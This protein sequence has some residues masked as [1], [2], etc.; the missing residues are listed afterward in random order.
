MDTGDSLLAECNDNSTD[1][2]SD[3]EDGLSCASSDV[4]SEWTVPE[5][6]LPTEGFSYKYRSDIDTEKILEQ[7]TNGKDDTVDVLIEHDFAVNGADKLSPD[8][9]SAVASLSTK[10]SSR[11][12]PLPS[13]TKDHTNN[14]EQ[15]DSD[16]DSLESLSSSGSMMDESEDDNDE[17]PETSLPDLRSF[18]NHALLQYHLKNAQLSNTRDSSSRKSAIHNRSDPTPSGQKQKRQR[19]ASTA[20]SEERNTANSSSQGRKM[21]VETS[22]DRDAYILQ[23]VLRWEQR[24]VRFDWQS[25]ARYLHTTVQSV[26]QRYAELT[27]VRLE[28]VPAILTHR[29]PTKTK[30]IINLSTPEGQNEYIIRRIEQWHTNK[31]KFCWE[32]LMTTL[33]WTRQA[34]KNRV[35]KLIKEGIIDSALV[36]SETEPIKLTLGMEPGEAQD[37]FLLEQVALAKSQKHSTMWDMIGQKMGCTNRTARRRYTY[38]MSAMFEPLATCAD[39]APTTATNTTT[40]ITA[41]PE[42]NIIDLTEDA[43][44]NTPSNVS[45]LHASQMGELETYVLHCVRQQLWLLLPDNSQASLWRQLGVELGLREIELKA[46]WQDKLRS[47]FLKNYN[48]AATQGNSYSS[49]YWFA[50]PH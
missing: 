27:G 36:P 21:I 15:M 38:L 2:S 39:S 9:G 49:S 40:D 12:M 24:G 10:V 4:G 11:T 33:G 6:R 31:Q 37:K 28:T 1:S 44:E 29:Q 47:V 18:A 20:S 17:V 30:T 7:I 41:Q 5:P 34:T 19:T 46:M 23:R 26:R 50:K 13:P 43:D 32:T 8:C 22:A 14:K 45:C 25:V 42:H 16:S 48:A 3:E 35:Y